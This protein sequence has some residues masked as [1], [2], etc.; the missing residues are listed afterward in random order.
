[1]SFQDAKTNWINFFRML[2]GKHKVFPVKV[3]RND[4]AKKYPLINIKKDGDVGY[5]LYSVEQVRVPAMSAEQ[6][7]AYHEIVAERDERRN[8]AQQLGLAGA[9]QA[10]DEEYTQKLTKL[11][12]RAVVPTGIF[13]ELPNSIWCS[14][15]ARSS[16]SQKLL[17]TPDAIIDSGYRGELFAVVFNLGVEDYIIQEGERVVQAIF[18][19]KTIA[20]IVEVEELASSVRGETGFGSSGL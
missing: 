16:S 9:I 5:D 14:I 2:V 19:E 12:P 13:L 3:K 6:R 8:N 11:L 15:E 7:E 20:T 18:H 10:I 4:K 1:M 17:I